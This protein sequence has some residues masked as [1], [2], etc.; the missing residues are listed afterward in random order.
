[1]IRI[2]QALLRPAPP[3]DAGAPPPLAPFDATARGA[4]AWEQPKRFSPRWNLTVDG[5]V[6]A[7][8]AVRGVFGHGAEGRSGR[9]HWRFRHGLPGNVTVFAN[10]ADMPCAR[11]RPGWFAGGLIDRVGLETLSW[12]RENFWQTRWGIQTADRLP[13]IHLHP[14]RGVLLRKEA[15]PVELEDAARR[16]PDLPMLIALGWFL[17][18]RSHRSHAAHG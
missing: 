10:G 3:P 9:D 7:T 18:L 14:H 1:M 4:W 13:L 2:L 15:S 8:L 5:A 16:L 12:R 11:Y 6:V 17:V